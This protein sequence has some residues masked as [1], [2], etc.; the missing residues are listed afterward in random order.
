MPGIAKR[1]QPLYP[2]NLIG[3]NTGKE[4]LV[5]RIKLLILLTAFF[6]SLNCASIDFDKK[7]AKTFWKDITLTLQIDPATG[8]ITGL[9]YTS[10]K[11]RLDADALGAISEGLARGL[12]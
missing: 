12:K 4:F 11:S 10:K 9:T 2:G 3:E 8:K 7:T 1:T 6:L 5:S